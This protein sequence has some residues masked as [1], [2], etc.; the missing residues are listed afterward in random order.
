LNGSGAAS[1]STT[2]LSVGSRV[3]TAAYQGDSNNTGST[4][5]SVTV[6]VTAP[7][8]QVTVGTTP[9]GLSFSVD[10]T[11][12]TSSQV[13]TWTVGS[14]HT[15]A[16][17]SPQTSGSTQNTFASWSDAG[18]LSHSVTAPASAASYTATFNTAYQLTTSASPTAA[19]RSHRHPA[20][21]TLPVQS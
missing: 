18:A 7:T 8:V 2:A 10:G 4:S 20:R 11:T 16:S 6:V 3:I 21:S 9:A 12:Y 15:L 14:S 19:E 5:S 13:L 1:F 17:T